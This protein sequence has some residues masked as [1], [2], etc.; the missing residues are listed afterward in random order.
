ME[1]RAEA[2]ALARELLALNA[3]DEREQAICRRL[4]TICP[5][6]DWSGHVFHSDAY[7]G[8]DGAFDY[9]RWADRVFAYRPITL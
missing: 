7:V 3:N 9:E 5:D 6:P 4:D 2:I 8:A 1:L